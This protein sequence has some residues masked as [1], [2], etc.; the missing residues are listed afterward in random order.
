[1]LELDAELGGIGLVGE[2]GILHVA[3]AEEV[4]AGPHAFPAV[5]RPDHILRVEGEADRVTLAPKRR[6]A[7]G[8]EGLEAVR[9]DDGR[10]DAEGDAVELRHRTE[11]LALEFGHEGVEARGEVDGETEKEDDAPED[12]FGPELGVDAEDVKT[13]A[14]ADVTH[15]VVAVVAEAH[16]EADGSHHE[17][18]G[19]VLGLE[20]VAHHEERDDADV[21]H[22]LTLA[23]AQRAGRVA[24]EVAEDHV[25]DADGKKNDEET[26]PADEVVEGLG[27]RD[28]L[29]VDGKSIVRHDRLSLDV[30]DA[31]D[32][33]GDVT[34]VHEDDDG[35]GHD[36]EPPR[37]LFLLRLEDEK[38]HG[39]GEH[40]KF[41]EFHDQPIRLST[42]SPPYQAGNGN[43]PRKHVLHRCITQTPATQC[44]LTTQAVDYIQ[45]AGLGRMS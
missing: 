39:G 35:P 9:G 8:P 38:Q 34:D 26:A 28:V 10:D 16:V 18:R 12:D 42:S 13:E 29:V 1:M 32:G 4:D 23:P 6:N 31:E 3:L 5:R 33:V 2:V 36:E 41:Q 27:L 15:G 19:E 45:W 20:A 43:A 37:K 44:F 7:G 25:G 14:L 24:H 11:G 21:G 17:H 22:F 30:E 40:K